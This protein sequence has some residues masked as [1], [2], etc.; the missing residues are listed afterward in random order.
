MNHPRW[1]A[2][3]VGAGAHLLDPRVLQRIG[4]LELVAREVVEGF[5]HGLHRSPFVGQSLDFAEHRAY[6]PGDDLRRM[7]WRVLARTDRYF[8]KEFEAET[9]ADFTVVLDRS[10]SMSFGSG[11]VRKFDHARFLGASLAYLAR[12]QGDRVGVVTF[13]DGVREVVPCSA[14]HLDLVLLTLDRAEPDRPGELGPALTDLGARARRRGILALVSDLYVEP[15]ELAGAVG[16]LR[17]AGN[18]VLVFQVL[19]PAERE[20][21]YR[22]AL[23]VE[24]LETGETLPVTPEALREDYRELV[25]RHVEAV[26][27]ALA[28]VGADHA[29]VDTS[30]PLEEVLFHYLSARQERRR[31]GR[32]GSRS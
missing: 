4:N 22:E 18:E 30:R 23:T 12:R 3:A 31:S 32:W 26:R 7:D 2:E 9:N 10:R 17:A 1:D 13:D 25:A 14:R 21:P 24:D 28:G 29:P 16:R 19:D 8:V 15:D 6:A 27:R 11:E 5:L 20:L